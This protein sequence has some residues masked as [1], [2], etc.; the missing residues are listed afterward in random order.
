[1]RRYS[2]SVMIEINNQ[3]VKTYDYDEQKQRVYTYIRMCV[4]RN[5]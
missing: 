2:K 1:M 4:L 3:F 5:L